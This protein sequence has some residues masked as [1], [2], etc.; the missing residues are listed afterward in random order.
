[1]VRYE[2]RS[3][4]PSDWARVDEIE[5]AA[6][7][8]SNEAQLVE[9]VRAEADPC[10][11]LVAARNRELVGHVLFSPVSIE[12]AAEAPPICALGPLAVWPDHQGEGVGSALIQDGLRECVAL[13]WQAVFLLGD[14]AY[15]SRFGFQL[16]APQDFHYESERFDPAFQMI[17][18]V[19]GVMS[20]WRGRVH[21]HDA[22]SAT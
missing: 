9:I 10:L 14:P 12:G 19:P 4:T 22:F 1:M 17:E 15:Y 20:P 18:L 13:G 16:A 2:V 7:G 21:Y 5:K 11:S 8:R 6:F 3:E